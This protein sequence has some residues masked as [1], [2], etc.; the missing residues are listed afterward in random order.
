MR[1]AKISFMSSTSPYHVYIHAPWCKS[2][3]PYCDFTV[4][5][6]RN[7]PFA[8]WQNKVIKDWQY[9]MQNSEWNPL[10]P[11]TIYFGGG[12]PSLVSTG[13]LATLIDTIRT[14]Q[15][16]EVTVEVNPGD[17]TFE[18]L[19]IL[20]SIGVTRLSLGI[21]TFNRKHLRRL[22]R[23]NT[24]K[25]CMQL[26]KWV[27]RVG[28]DSWSMDLMFG[29]PD[30]TLNEL[31]EDIT[32]ILQ[33]HPPHVSLYGLT[34]KEGT[35]LHKALT[36][37]KLSPINED[38]W[39]EQFKDIASRLENAGYIRYEVSNFCNPP[40]QAKHNEGIWKN[41]HYVGLG[42]GAHGFWTNGTR[43][44]YPTRWNDWLQST[45]P[46]IETC[47]PEQRAL[48]W[49]ITA[50]RHRDGI[51]MPTLKDMGYT[52]NVPKEIR[53]IEAFHSG[54]EQTLNHVKLSS[55]GWILVDWITEVLADALTPI[56]KQDAL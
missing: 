2:K 19:E 49:M 4:Y 10:G 17:V 14:P 52:L 12:T 13:I 3:C 56:S 24:P 25:D 46:L 8:E 7:P 53:G 43:T 40:H 33:I 22:G 5:V 27:D 16:T 20:R 26:L 29:L 35:P 32:R 44:Q 30:Q 1:M 37:G 50:I 34:Y 54:V 23:G 11:D 45:M 48:D 15:T 38:I 41:E 47:S 28:F 55:K 18:G 21:Q 36:S 6:D 9:T 51:F 31:N 42:P 39:I